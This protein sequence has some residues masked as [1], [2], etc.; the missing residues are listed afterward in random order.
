M[1]RCRRKGFRLVGVVVTLLMFLLSFSSVAGAA[2]VRER[3]IDV[4]SPEESFSEGAGVRGTYALDTQVAVDKGGNIWVWGY[5]NLC[6]IDNAGQA[7]ASSPNPVNGA[8]YTLDPANRAFASNCARDTDYFNN[9]PAVIKG[10]TG[11]TSVAGSSY[12]LMAVDKRGN[13]YGWGDNSQ[14]GAVAPSS[15]SLMASGYNRNSLTSGGVFGI[16]KDGTAPP[17]A[18]P[19]KVNQ[20]NPNESPDTWKPVDG[21]DAPVPD[22]GSDGPYAQG[23]NRNKVISVA[24][25][26]YGFAYLKDDGSVWTVGHNGFGQRGIGKRGGSQAAWGTLKNGA[27]GYPFDEGGGVS[28]RPTKVLFPEGVKIKYL[29]NS[30]EG[31]HAVDIDNNVWFWGR[32]YSG[33]S[34]L[35]QDDINMLSSKKPRDTD[36]PCTTLGSAALDAYCYLPVQVPSITKVVKENGFQKFAEG[37]EYGILLDA[38]KKAWIWGSSTN[39]VGMP[40]YTGTPGDGNWNPTPTLFAATTNDDKSFTADNIVDVNGG[41]HSGQMVTGDGY[42][43]GW[44]EAY[45]GGAQFADLSATS[46]NSP[47]N[48]SHRVGVVWDPTRDPQHRKATKVGGNKDGANFNLEDGSIY[49]WGENGGGAALGGRGYLG[50]TVCAEGLPGCVSPKIGMSGG[51]NQGGLYVWPATFVPD[52]QN[53]GR[54]Q[55]AIKNAYPFQGTAVHKGDTVEYTLQIVNDRTSYQNPPIGIEDTWGNAASLVPGSLRAKY[56]IYNGHTVNADDDPQWDVT[57]K[58]TAS[59]TG[60]VSN[61]TNMVLQPQSTLVVR[62]KVKVEAGT[63]NVGGRLLLKKLADGSEI[64]SDKTSN[65]VVS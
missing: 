41:F 52:I 46:T 31:Y 32:N 63:G 24:S 35:S 10:V 36:N 18:L 55:T 20:M 38:H 44:G 17:E 61:D 16:Y 19:N 28:T 8:S 54:Y 29:S 5:Y 6:S 11:F 2:Y 53:V 30:Y 1:N 12:A 50:R 25:N 27:S 37:Y 14:D 4:S 49:T 43:Y 62:Y 57:S 45:L 59:P 58:F 26:E 33:N 56:T 40:D 64:D 15:A 9:K 21:P 47:W 22:G 42:V 51:R 60:I 39:R 13:L 34:G 48:S 7:G 23:F 65:P 3:R